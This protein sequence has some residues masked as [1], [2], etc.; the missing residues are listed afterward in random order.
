MT[1]FYSKALVLEHV[2]GCHVLATAVYVNPESEKSTD[3]SFALQCLGGRGEK[4]MQII[5]WV[6]D[7]KK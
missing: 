2:L 6:N 1:E 3:R 5:V 7:G 4:K